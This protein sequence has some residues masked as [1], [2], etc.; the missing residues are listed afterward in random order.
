VVIIKDMMLSIT[1]E[2]KLT[3]TVKISTFAWWRVL[4][5]HSDYRPTWCQNCAD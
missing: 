3:A 4:I 2:A 5:S 1:D